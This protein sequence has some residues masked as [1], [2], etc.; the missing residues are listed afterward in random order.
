MRLSFE[1]VVIRT[2]HPFVI[3]RG[4]GSEFHRVHLELAY[5]ELIGRGEAAPSAYYGEDASSVRRALG[6]LAQLVKDDPLV[7]EE[8]ILE[9]RARRPRDASARA[10]LDMALHDLISQTWGVP[11]HQMFGLRGTGL[12]PT[13]LTIAIDAPDKMLSRAR[14]ARDFPILKVKVGWEGDVAFLRRLREETDQKIRVDANEGWPTETAVEKVLE[15]DE[16]VGVELVEQPCPA[17]DLEG[18]ARVTEVSPVPIIADES[19]VDAAD[20]PRVA[21]S[22]HGINVKLAK[23][24]GL[25]EA[26]VMIHLARRMGLEVMIGCMVESSLGITAAAHLGAAADYL[27]LDGHLLLAEDPFA[28]VRVESGGMALPSEPGIGARPT[29]KSRKSQNSSS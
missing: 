22:V 3:A 24:G 13:S 27:D 21:G 26:R 25:S 6:E 8:T 16:E 4:G 18:M 5:G 7:W 23:C 19:C 10:A 1:E 14:E 9:A 15:L 29:R 20:V 2:R 17:A 28:G 11:L 12:P